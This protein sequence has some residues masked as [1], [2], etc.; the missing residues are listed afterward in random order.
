[1]GIHAV[2]QLV[3]HLIIVGFLALVHSLADICATLANT[4]AFTAVKALKECPAYSA[5]LKVPVHQLVVT[6]VQTI[7]APTVYH[8]L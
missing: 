3:K 2:V 7:H 5:S 4:M 6:R 1:V 8:L